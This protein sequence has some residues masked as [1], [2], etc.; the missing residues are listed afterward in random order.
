M[1]VEFKSVRYDSKEAYEKMLSE[2]ISGISS[3]PFENEDDYVSYIT[4][5]MSTVIDFAEGRVH[6]NGEELQ[7]VYVNTSENNSIPNLLISYAEFKN[8]FQRTTKERVYSVE[9]V[10]IM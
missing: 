2:E 8:V 4:V 3:I 1:I 7:C 10:K 6:L 5:D 9:E